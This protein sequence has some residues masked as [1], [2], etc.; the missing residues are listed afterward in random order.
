[1]NISHLRFVNV[2]NLNIRN[3]SSATK[4]AKILGQ[5]NLGDVIK[6]IDKKKNWTKIYFE[7]ENV[8]IKGWVF[9]R[10][11]SKFKK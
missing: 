11:I 6:I 10:Y 9:T 1:M 5:L 3:I 8:T 4:K 7:N 2:N